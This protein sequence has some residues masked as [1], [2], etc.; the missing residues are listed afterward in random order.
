MKTYPMTQHNIPED[1]NLQ[2]HQCES[3]KHHNTFNSTH[4]LLDDRYTAIQKYLY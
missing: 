1:L 4:T 3:L 2:Q